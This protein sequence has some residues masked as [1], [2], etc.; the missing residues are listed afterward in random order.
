MDW[1][2]AVGLLVLPLAI[3]ALMYVA[4][5]LDD[6]APDFPDLRPDPPPLDG[7]IFDEVHRWREADERTRRRFCIKDERA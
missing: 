2:L 5:Y 1:L 7:L 3:V 6:D 4:D